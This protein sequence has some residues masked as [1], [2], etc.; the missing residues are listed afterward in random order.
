MAKRGKKD[1]PE[2]TEEAQQD[3]NPAV[4][5]LAQGL[6][7]NASPEESI[8]EADAQTGAEAKAGAQVLD[9]TGGGEDQS[10]PE[11]AE[12]APA[13]TVEKLQP[14]QIPPRKP[15]KKEQKDERVANQQQIKPS[16][17]LPKSVGG[18]RELVPGAEKIK[19]HLRK[20]DGKRGL[21]GVFGLK[22]IPPGADAET[23][24][25]QVLR[26]RF[27]GGHYEFTLVDGQRR[28]FEGGDAEILDLAADTVSSEGIPASGP[29][30]LS[31]VKDFMLQDREE[32]QRRSRELDGLRTKPEKDPIEMLG[33]MK[34]LQTKFEGDSKKGDDGTLAAVIQNMGQQTQSFMQML[35]QQQA[36]AED[37]M[38]TLLTTLG[39]PR[40]DKSEPI[41]LALL[42]KLL[43]DKKPSSGGGAALP[44]PPD[45][46]AELKNLAE[47]VHLL[48]PPKDEGNK[49]IEYLI[50]REEKER[51]SPRDVIELFNKARGEPGTDDFRKSMDNFGAMMQAMESFRQRLEPGGATGFFDA[52]GALFSNRDFATSIAG[53]IRTKTTAAQRQLATGAGPGAGADPRLNN[54]G[55]AAAAVDQQTRIIEARRLA[56]AKRRLEAENAALAEEMAQHP[57]SHAPR[58]IEEE[59]PAAPAQQ[60]R[61]PVEQGQMP[62]VQQSA[63]PDTVAQAVA[64]LDGQET[65]QPEEEAALDPEH[66]AAVERAR[67]QTGGRLPQLPPDIADY[68]NNIVAADDDGALAESVI[69]LLQYLGELPDWERFANTA[70]ALMQNGQK[71]QSLQFIQAFFEGLATIQLVLP[72]VVTNVV[73]VFNEHFEEVVEHTR[74]ASG[75]DDT[76]DVDAT[77]AEEGDEEDGEEDDG[78]VEDDLVPSE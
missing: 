48:Q 23:F 15:T 60:V 36:K 22:E 43:E 57:Q 71:E 75:L 37:R 7:I 54:G 24:A 58:R 38:I 74:K 20:A 28:E 40:E 11:P 50:A 35:V 64:Q 55:A 46:T 73:R 53:A 44:P 78:P 1:Q 16:T 9:I 69:R 33:K 52:L 77:D 14:R 45:P 72:E 39:A 42:T 47:V 8:L 21:L 51:L 49:I 18:L 17:T 29:S 19:I 2:Q 59:A 63:A 61:A 67:A 56:L 10:A 27:G 32:R 4:D 30:P 25:Y 65:I 66:A 34:D 3:G 6:D 5:E 26:P 31:L 70:F 76:E 68:I 12:A 62:T 41:M 13:G